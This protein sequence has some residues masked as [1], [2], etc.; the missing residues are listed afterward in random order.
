M[1]KAELQ[2]IHKIFETESDN[3][4]TVQ[5][6]TALDGVT[7]AFMPGEIHTIL[8]ENGAGKSTL[9]HILSG[10]HQPSRGCIRIGGQAFCFNSPSDA[11]TAGIAMVH[12]RPLLSDNITVLENILIGFPDLFLHR[13]RN[14]KTIAELAAQWH[15]PINLDAPAH[16]LTASQRM[17]TAL[18]GALFRKPD[19][20]ILDEPAAVLAPEERE[21]FFLAMQN[22]RKSGLGIILI[23]HKIEEAVRWSDRI[24]VL[25]RGRLIYTELLQQTG[26]TRVET[27]E[28]L[29]NLIEGEKT[30]Q[31]SVSTNSNTEPLSGDVNFSVLNLT[32]DNA[33]RNPIYNISFTARQGTVTGIFGLAGSGIETLEDILTGMIRADSGTIT[34]AHTAFN[35]PDINPAILRKYRVAFVPSDRGFR[36]AHLSLTIS[37]MLIPYQCTNFFLTRKD[38]AVFVKNILDSEEIDA[39]PTRTVQTLSGGQLQRLILRRELAVQPDILILSN[40]EWGLDIRSTNLLRER[41]TQAATSGMTVILLNDSLD[42]LS[43]CALYSSTL[44]LRDGRLS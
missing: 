10:L 13:K 17:Y 3:S 33:H 44:I 37:D 32:A 2:D 24:S 39:R 18:L 38:N 22:S 36:A 42:S 8:G 9:V 23:T 14:K 19:F 16:T 15:I 4:L 35:A 40:P 34:I 21:Q 1:K 41:L 28:L 26:Q 20:L 27:L 11:L 25:R 29:E 7:L 5:R 43:E 30:T 12:Q 31:A 6:F